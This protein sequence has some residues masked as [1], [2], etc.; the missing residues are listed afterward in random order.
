MGVASD[1]GVVRMKLIYDGYPYR[2]GLL[3]VQIM[4]EGSVCIDKISDIGV[5]KAFNYW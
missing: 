5:F 1:R 4:K 2:T 3:R